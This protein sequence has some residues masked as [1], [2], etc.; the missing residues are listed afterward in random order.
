MLRRRVICKYRG[1]AGGIASCRAS[2]ESCGGGAVPV[3]GIGKIA[4]IRHTYT[5]EQDRVLSAP[6]AHSILYLRAFCNTYLA[7]TRSHAHCMPTETKIL[8]IL[9]QK[10]KKTLK[11]RTALYI[12]R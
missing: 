4:V 8:Y 6:Y 2:R 12:I 7:K 11:K 10:R 5:S 9:P 3:F 1:R